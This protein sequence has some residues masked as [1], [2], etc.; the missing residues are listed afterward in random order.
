MSYIDLTVH[1]VTETDLVD[2]AVQQFQ[3]NA[4]TWDPSE[5][6]TESLLIEALAVIVGQDVYAINQ[7]PRITLTG[8][9]TLWGVPRKPGVGA[10]A[11]VKVT[12]AAGTSGSRTIPAGTGFRVTTPNGV[13]LEMQSTTDVIADPGA[14]LLVYVPVTIT[15]AGVLGNAIP[16]GTVVTLAQPVGWVESASLFTTSSG[17]QDPEADD[18]YFS[19]AAGFLQ[20]QT[21]ALVIP[22]HFEAWML[23]QTSVGRAKCIT[24]WD[25]SGTVGAVTGYVTVAVTDASGAAL[26][27]GVKADLQARA[28][29]LMTAGLTLRVVDPVYSTNGFSV[30]VT[31]QPGVDKP[32]LQAA[33]V[34]MLKAW[35]SPGSWPWGQVL[36]T[37]DLITKVQTFPGVLRVTAQTGAALDAAVTSPIQLPAASVVPTVTVN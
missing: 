16:A 10:S 12:I 36:Y 6:D 20:R 25:G 14:G 35:Y 33:L 3:V 5:G 4:P 11:T 2:A 29:A 22:A 13:V 24:L 27:T 31:A 7:I 28:T 15:T 21:S 17:G 1:Q 8:L 18:D 34:A 19:R 23:D 32:T 26:S 30:T 9:L 37:N